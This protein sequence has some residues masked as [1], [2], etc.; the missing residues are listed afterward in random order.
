MGAAALLSLFALLEFDSLE[1]GLL[2]AEVPVS[3]VAAAEPFSLLGAWPLE[4]GVDEALW[5]VL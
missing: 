1:A 3:D 5:S 4:P 2:S